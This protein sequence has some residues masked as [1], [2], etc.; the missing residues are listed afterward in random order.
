LREDKEVT[1]AE[2]DRLYQHVCQVTGDLRADMER[3][4]E[5][6]APLAAAAAQAQGQVDT[7]NAEIEV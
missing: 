2:V 7:V 5:E 3:R 6:L 4:Q 1:L